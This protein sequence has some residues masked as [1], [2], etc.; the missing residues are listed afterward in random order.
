MLVNTVSVRFPILQK[1]WNPE[2]PFELL[3]HVANYVELLI[4]I[5]NYVE[6]LI[7]VANYFELLI[8]VP[9]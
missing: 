5:A 9:N 4:H 8:H 3:I 2:P 1:E 6:L 7:H